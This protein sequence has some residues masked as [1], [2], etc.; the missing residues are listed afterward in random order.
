MI[1]HFLLQLRVC[2][3]KDTAAARI[4]SAIRV[5]STEENRTSTWAFKKNPA[6]QRLQGS[7]LYLQ[8]TFLS[9]INTRLY[10]ILSG[11]QKLLILKSS[12]HRVDQ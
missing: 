5:T 3:L 8:I 1:R 6:P 10:L 4:S 7:S 11:L 9:S 12:A 2:R